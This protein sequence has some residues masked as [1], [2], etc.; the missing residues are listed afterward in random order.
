MIPTEY[1]PD[2]RE[3]SGVMLTF[4]APEPSAGIESSVELKATSLEVVCPV[5]EKV[6][7]AFNRMVIGVDKL[8]FTSTVDWT[9]AP[10]RTVVEVKETDTP[11]DEDTF[12][13][14]SEIWFAP[15]SVN[16]KFP[17]ASIVL[18]TEYAGRVLGI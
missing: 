5:E 9:K 4:R 10:A 2:G 13:G 6:L 18:S 15:N 12:A 16:Q 17:S 11:S 8:L 1:V 3:E 7:V 14:I